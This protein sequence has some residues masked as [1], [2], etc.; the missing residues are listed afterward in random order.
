MNLQ[1][2]ISAESPRRDPSSHLRGNFQLDQLLL[3]V[4]IASNMIAT[5]K[6]ETFVGI[7]SRIGCLLLVTSLPLLCPDKKPI[8]I[9]ETAPAPR[10]PV[11]AITIRQ[12]II[13]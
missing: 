8:I 6:E 9:V 13:I 3:S 11:P 12:C 1:T 10:V 4:E 5:A 7:G 2:P